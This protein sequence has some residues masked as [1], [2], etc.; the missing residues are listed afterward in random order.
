MLKLTPA[1]RSRLREQAHGLNPVVMVGDAGLTDG[2]LKEISSSLDAHGLIKIRVFGDDRAN[3]I[4]I[5]QTICTELNAAP[6]QH[7]GKLL[8]VYRHKK[9]KTSSL[10]DD[11]KSRGIREVKTIRPGSGAV[12]SR[13]KKVAVKGNERLTAG[14][15]V[16]RAKVRQ[17]SAK[18]KSLS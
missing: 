4:D 1:E 7:I 5:Y 15:K 12:R 10:F 13:V 16:K 2:V 8:V 9:E 11:K 6:I 18:K 17:T 14:G 3:R